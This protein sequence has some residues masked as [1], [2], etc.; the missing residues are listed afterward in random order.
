MNIDYCVEQLKSLC[1]IDS[2]SGFTEEVADYLMKE[3][4]AL[5]YKPERTKK[6]G[7]TVCLGG[8]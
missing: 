7:V 3:L 1:A 5:G 6:G 4:E 8:E 2:P